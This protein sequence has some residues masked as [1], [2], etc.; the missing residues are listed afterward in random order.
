MDLSAMPGSGRAHSPVPPVFSSVQFSSGYGGVFLVEFLHRLATCNRDNF[1]PF[2]LL[3]KQILH[4]LMTV[5]S[6]WGTFRPFFQCGLK[7]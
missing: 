6:T 5:C 1:A 2:F 3:R 4:L 7:D